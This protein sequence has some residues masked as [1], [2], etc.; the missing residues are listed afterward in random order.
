MRAKGWRIFSRAFLRTKYVRSI[1][2]E[3]STHIKSVT[4][5]E[6]CTF[7]SLKSQVLEDQDEDSS[8]AQ[9]KC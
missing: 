4:I 1:F 3:L 2:L 5:F 6:S 8:E 7:F 9:E